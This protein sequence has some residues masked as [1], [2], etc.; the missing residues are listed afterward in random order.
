M[1][2]IRTMNSY[3][4]LR[5]ACTV[6]SELRFTWKTQI[7]FCQAWLCRP[8]IEIIF[9][10]PFASVFLNVQH[11]LISL[12]RVSEGVTVVVLQQSLLE[13]VVAELRPPCAALLSA[14]SW[15]P[16]ARGVCDHHGGQGQLLTAQGP[17]NN[18]HPL[19]S[20]KPWQN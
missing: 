13:V 19:D 17:G 9:K 11:L 6:L 14:V 8:T 15:I 4:T 18:T 1:Y 7:H 12:E 10:L 2:G 5:H 3:S 20:G 16:R